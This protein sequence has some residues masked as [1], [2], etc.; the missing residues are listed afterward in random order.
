M[1]IANTEI[2]YFIIVQ[3]TPEPEIEF[4]FEYKKINECCE[5]CGLRGDACVHISQ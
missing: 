3:H 1:N 5:R 4:M 2:L